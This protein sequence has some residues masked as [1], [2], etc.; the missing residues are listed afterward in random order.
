MLVKIFFRIAPNIMSTRPK[1]ASLCEDSEGHAQGS[2]DFADAEKDREALAHPDA[3]GAGG[4][5]FEMA[6]A[7][8]DKDEADH[9]ARRRIPRSVKRASCGNMATV[10]RVQLPG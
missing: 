2:G 3:L 9:R 7:A 8:G 10:G 6:I 4:G 5:I 1:A